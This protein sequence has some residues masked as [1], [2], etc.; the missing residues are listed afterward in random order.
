[1]FKHFSMMREKHGAK[2]YGFVPMSYVLPHDMPQLQEAMAKNPA[3]NY[4]FKPSSAAQGR[5][6]FITNNF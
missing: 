2:H 6:I 3:R 4:I 5:G 1:M